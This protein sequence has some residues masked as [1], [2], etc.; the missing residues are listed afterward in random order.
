[1]IGSSRVSRALRIAV[2]AMACSTVAVLVPVKAANNGIAASVSGAGLTTVD[3]ELRT[4]SFVAHQGEDGEA[5]GMAQINNRS[6]DEMFQLSVD[7]LNIFENLAIVSGVI[8]R[9]TD[10]HAIGLTG[11][12]AV[13]DTGEGANAPPDFISQVFFFEPGVLSC[14][15]LGPA[16]AEPFLEPIDAGNIQ[17]RHT[18]SF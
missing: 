14:A 2:V 1:M 17:V 3:G 4:F 16:D 10:T 15:D 5:S 6:V 9:H 11:I 13:L 7:C 18:I 8:T 12:F